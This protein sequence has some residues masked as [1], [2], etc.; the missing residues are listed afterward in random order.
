MKIATGSRSSATVPVSAPFCCGRA[1]RDVVD[2]D[3]SDPPM[4]V[5]AAA[6][7]CLDGGSIITSSFGEEL[8]E[9]TAPGDRPLE[10]VKSC[11]PRVK[12]KSN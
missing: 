6:V 3:L 10:G 7:W 11:W 8:I 2:D 9:I 4:V 12:K 1:S 5:R